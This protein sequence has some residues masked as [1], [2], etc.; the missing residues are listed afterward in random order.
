MSLVPNDI[1]EILE[2][3]KSKD[4]Y[5]TLNTITKKNYNELEKY[6]GKYWYQYFYL[7]YHINNQINNIESTKIKKDNIINKYG[8]E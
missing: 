5:T 2:F 8:D 3:I 6:Y 1:L 4:L 7:S